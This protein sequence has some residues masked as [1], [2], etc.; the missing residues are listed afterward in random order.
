MKRKEKCQC[1]FCQQEIFYDD[2]ICQTCGM[3]FFLCSC[4]QLVSQKDKCCPKCGEKVK[5]KE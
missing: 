4:G 5:E 1:P 3:A 2:L